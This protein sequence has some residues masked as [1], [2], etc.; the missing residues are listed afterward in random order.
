MDGSS[1]LPLAVLGLVGFGVFKLVKGGSGDV[2]YCTTCG[3]EAPA[4]AVTK[5][6]IGIEVILW[7]FFLVPGLIYSIWRLT[8]KHRACK[9]CGSTAIIPPNSPQAL[10]AKKTRAQE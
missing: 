1:L 6:S 4:K 7:L 2:V 8:T 3:S 10:A 9:V 5:G